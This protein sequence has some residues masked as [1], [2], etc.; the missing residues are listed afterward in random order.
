MC[1]KQETERITD[2]KWELIIS[3]YVITYLMNTSVPWQTEF[4]M[5]A[6]RTKG[7]ALSEQEK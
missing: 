7:P 3:V 5:N 4:T 6:H 2:D 1:Y